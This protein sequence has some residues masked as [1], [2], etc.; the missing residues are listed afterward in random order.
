MDN[1]KV[2]FIDNIINVVKY[3]IGSF[4]DSFILV[5]TF[6]IICFLVGEINTKSV[7]CTIL[8]YFAVRENF[9]LLKYQMKKRDSKSILV[10]IK[11]HSNSIFKLIKGELEEKVNKLF[12]SETEQ[13]NVKFI[14][15]F[16]YSQRVAN[17]K[18]PKNVERIYGFPIYTIL[19]VNETTKKGKVVWSLTPTVSINEKKIKDNK[20]IQANSEEYFANIRAIE[21]DNSF[22]G[23]QDLSISIF[24]AFSY[25]FGLYIPSFSID[26]NNF[27]IVQEIFSNAMK[28][29][30]KQKKIKKRKD[31]IKMFEIYE[32]RFERFRNI[33]IQY[34]LQS[35]LDYSELEKKIKFHGKKDFNK[36]F[37]FKEIEDLLLLLKRTDT[38][39]MSNIYNLC[40]VFGFLKK[41]PIY[42]MNLIFDEHYEYIKKNSLDYQAQIVYYFYRGFFELYINDYEHA[43]HDYQDAINIIKMQKIDNDKL[44]E[45]VEEMHDFLNFAKPEENDYIFDIADFILEMSYKKSEFEKKYKEITSSAKYTQIPTVFRMQFEKFHEENTRE[46]QNA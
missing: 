9:W 41:D 24:L 38:I 8:V 40:E 44:E 19:T 27:A 23:I 31:K 21:A 16:I 5:I 36:I 39:N 35:I 37:N 34:R 6:T 26:E 2:F 17:I 30:Q 28:E 46:K 12:E 4:T 14:D 29:C 43:F 15:D 1:L 18:N 7:L 10:I 45:I 22:Y 20:E 3:F 33:A 13:I 11:T 25:I 42:K 32:R